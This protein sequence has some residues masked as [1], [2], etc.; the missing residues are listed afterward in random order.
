[1]K[2]PGE[3]FLLGEWI[4]P[5]DIYLGDERPERLLAGPEPRD[6]RDEQMFSAAVRFSQGGAGVL[7][8]AYP[9]AQPESL[10]DGGFYLPRN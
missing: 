6:R 7:I 3:T 2:L 8:A 1:M 4:V 10:A 9:V 5:I